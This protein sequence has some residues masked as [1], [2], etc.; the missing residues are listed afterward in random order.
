MDQ[1]VDVGRGIAWNKVGGGG[2]QWRH[3]AGKS[4]VN[5]S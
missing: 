3:R 1:D 5:G 4:R 2:R